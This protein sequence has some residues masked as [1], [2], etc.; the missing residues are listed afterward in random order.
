MEQPAHLA[1]KKKTKWY[2]IVMW[3]MIA[4]TLLIGLAAAI[5]ISPTSNCALLFFMIVAL[6]AY[7]E[8]SSFVLFFD[9]SKCHYYGDLNKTSIFLRLII[10]SIVTGLTL[11]MLTVA[12]TPGG[13]VLSI[14]CWS[15]QRCV[16]FVVS[17]FSTQVIYRRIFYRT[18]CGTM[19]LRMKLSKNVN[20]VY[21]ILSIKWVR[22][23]G[24]VLA[25][26]T[27]ASSFIISEA[28]SVS[29]LPAFLFC[30]AVSFSVLALALHRRA[31]ILIETVFLSIAISFGSFMAFVI[32]SETGVGLDDESHFHSAVSFSYV[33]YPQYTSAERTLIN[34]NPTA[35]DGGPERPAVDDW[36]ADKVDAWHIS[37]NASY[38]HGI[39][40]KY[41]HFDVIPS[42]TSISYAPMSFGLWLGRALQLPF[43]VIYCFGRFFN[44]LSYTI[45]TYIAI[46]VI[47]AKKTLLCTLALIPT[48]LFMAAS[49]SYDPWM[50]S[51]IF[52]GV[53]L[54]IRE[55]SEPCTAISRSS[56][57]GMLICFFLALSP[58]AVYF[59]VLGLLLCMPATKFE[60][61]ETRSHYYLSVIGMGVLAVV[62]FV[63]PYLS[64]GG[65]GYT[66]SRG[67]DSVNAALQIATIL[68][69]P[70]A[71]IKMLGNFV[72]N[73]YLSIS[74]SGGYFFQLGYA[75]D[76]RLIVPFVSSV[77]A[78]YLLIISVVDSDAVSSCLTS[79]KRRVYVAFIGLSAV[80]LI[81]T[82]MY[83][84][85]TPVG[86]N[87]VNGC[88][89]RYLLPLMF[90]VSVFCFG[91]PGI[92]NIYSR[93]Q[94]STTFCTISMLMI[95]IS[96]FAATIP[97]FTM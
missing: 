87:T 94:L 16:L 45:I 75:G 62:T 32:P 64:T 40:E 11:E 82:A 72:F 38:G 7:V 13:N 61:S 93:N 96:F 54:L 41:G 47:P 20:A 5:R 42:Y 26:A 21:N 80:V 95:M 6:L 25:V 88:Q 4:G 84:A 65:A 97:K 52:L 78:M 17:A 79:F 48:T 14:E 89:F 43:T 74:N 68:K 37:L 29:F 73:T 28:I 66:D 46:K 57:I 59:P 49:Y 22:L 35:L 86:L 18:T 58:K 90:P 60:R 15:M 3:S 81:A 12:G 8:Y 71:Y 50:I 70:L 39:T 67:G 36:N 44:L 92:R 53:A 51:W 85:F 23:L 10:T 2:R 55:L 24:V 9:K 76:L 56:W 30:L 27:L 34:I 33:I 1:K 63:I 31:L 91:F 69:D 83:V 77:P 19:K